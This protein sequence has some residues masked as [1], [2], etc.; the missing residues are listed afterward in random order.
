MMVEA[1]HSGALESQPVSSLLERLGERSLVLVGMMGAGKTSVGRKLAERLGLSFVDADHEIEL[2]AGMSIADIFAAHGEADFRA[3]EVRV[4]SRLLLSGP[5]IIATGGGAFMN[6]TTR[7]NIARH[8]I[9]IWL[10]AEPDVLMRRVRK[11]S[12]RPLL[13][14]ADPEA[15][16]RHLLKMREPVYA[17]ADITVESLE[18]PHERV[19]EAV[20]KAV[21]ERMI[22]EQHS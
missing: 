11:R 21:S 16:L 22:Q 15:T 4:I 7:E 14:T 2:A 9:S 19:V 1:S 3:G 13:K 12:D 8:G 10:K 6:E 17:L 5:K 18:A 20:M